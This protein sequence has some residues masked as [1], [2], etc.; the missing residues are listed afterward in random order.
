MLKQLNSSENEL[1]KGSFFL[2]RMPDPDDDL[3]DDDETDPTPP[4]P[5]PPVPPGS[6][7]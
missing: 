3:T 1:L 5:T 6:G 7:N 4:P 2:N